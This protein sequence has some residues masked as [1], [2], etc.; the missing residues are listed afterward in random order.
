MGSRFRLALVALTVLPALLGARPSAA[1]GAAAIDGRDLTRLVNPLSGSLGSGFPMVAAVRPFGM[2]EIGPNTGYLG[3]EDPVN[4]D[5][6]SYVDQTLRGFALTHFDGA[7]I[8]LAGDLPFLPTTGTVTSTNPNRIASL[9]HHSSEAAQPGYSAV[10][11]DRYSTRVEL[12]ATERAA[13]VRMTYPRTPQAN[14]MFDVSRSISGLHPGAITVLDA[15]TVAGW[16]RSENAPAGYLVYFTATLDH[17]ITS[18]GTWS[19]VAL[20]PGSRATS[21]N[22]NGGWITLD[23][24]AR[25]VVTMRVALS[26]VDAG[27]AAANLANEVPPAATLESVRRG[28]HDAWNARLHDIEVAGGE[29]DQL[30]TFYTN[31]YRSLL[32]PTIFDDADGRYAGFDHAI[33]RVASGTHHYT[34]L[35]LWDTYRTQNPL[36]ELIEPAVEHDVM[37]SMLDD[38][39]QNHQAIPRWTQANLDYGIMGGDSGS[40]FL[41]DGVMRG[42]LRGAEARRAYAALLHQAMTLPPVSAREHLDAYLHKGY[43]GYDISGIGTALTQEYAIDDHAVLQVARRLGD[44]PA[45]TA[46]TNRASSWRN[47][48]DPSSHFIRPR[49]SDGSWASPTAAG[50]VPLPWTPDFQDGYQEGTGWQ[51]LWL[52][53]QDVAGL[54]TAIGGRQA[55]LSR[56]DSFFSEALT[57]VPYLVPVAQQYTS[58]FGV[59]YIGNQ[60]TPAN[61]PDLQAGFYYDWLGQPWKTQEV[62][63]AA[64]QTYN[65]RPDGLPGNDDTGTMSAWYVLAAIGIY[66]ATP[67]VPVY[68]LTTPA[69][70]QVNIHLGALQRSFTISAVG[71]STTMKYARSATLDGRAFDRTF[72]TQCD[73]H[74]GGRL[75]WNVGATA[76]MWG[77]QAGAAPPSLSDPH[78]DANVATCEHTLG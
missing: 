27:G 75:D 43:V 39:D 7:G 9:Y 40:A 12:A 56:L 41:A 78:P 47:L 69:F 13:V 50:P 57:S 72:L 64:M 36:L 23:T 52:E 70:S 42:V 11:L 4:Y 59:Y 46:L 49:N 66:G 63:R 1:A 48:V 33:H 68:E 2:M 20:S 67:G 8:H 65:S 62:V 73:L 16:A 34:S 31:L 35:S 53:P 22:A 18:T 58:F 77:T 54:A 30:A 21:G 26:Y 76:S 24:T 6:Y 10:T 14:V 29:G 51:Y 37:I 28:A 5:G 71:A 25:P 61:E 17:V 32:M 38:Y 74:A 45:V 60:Y 44:R 19:G 3:A 15:H 55:T